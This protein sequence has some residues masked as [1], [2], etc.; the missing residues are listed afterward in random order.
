MNNEFIHSVTLDRDKC[1][2]CINCIKRCPTQAIR[3]REGKAAIN[4]L[5]CIDCAEC[6]RICPHHAKTASADPL[7]V[8]HNYEYTIA[9]P[10]PSF[11]AQFNNL[12]DP[13]QVV[14]A[15]LELGFDEVFEVARAAELVSEATRR[16]LQIGQVPRP[17]IS[18]ACPAVV[19]LIRVRYPDLIDHVLPLAP[20]I[21]VAARIAKKKAA[22]TTGLAPEKIGCIFLSPCPAKI[23]YVR[24]PIGVQHSA[25]DAAVGH[26]GGLPAPAVGAEKKPPRGR[27]PATPAASAWAG[28]ESGGESS[29]L[30]MVD[31]YL[32]AD[33][34]EN[35]IRV[36]EDLEDEN[37]G[38]WNLWNWTP[39]RAAAWGAY[40][41]WRTP[42]SPGQDE[43]AAP[44]PAGKPQSP[45][46][47]Q[48]PRPPCC[49]TPIWNT[50]PVLELSGTRSE[51]FE[52]YN[53]LRRIQ[54][55]LPGLDCG[56]CGAPSCEALAEDVVRGQASVDDC[57]VLMRRRMEAVLRA[58]NLN[59]EEKTP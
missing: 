22:E 31:D 21:E 51:R 13:D 34:I 18:S 28:G 45:A 36:L 56:S 50:P 5:R 8:L 29:G 17:A 27:A 43:E 25:V 4:P 33:G 55:S 37:T 15:L 2:G 42:T 9:L 57:T 47:H 24:S 30:V 6:I 59:G 32:A 26:Q 46:Q 40:C 53:Q 7:D 1:M 49:G 38:N 14:S 3:V 39:A 20:P 44:V 10:P 16:L 48:H 11:Y 23:S 35:V 41:R 58:L 19:R 54:E 12:E 52:K